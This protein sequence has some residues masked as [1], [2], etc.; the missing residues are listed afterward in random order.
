MQ[1][2]IASQVDL[3]AKRHCLTI[4]PIFGEFLLIQTVF[5]FMSMCGNQ[6]TFLPGSLCLGSRQHKRFFMSSKPA[7]EVLKAWGEVCLAIGVS[8]TL[9]GASL[10]KTP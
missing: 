8:S 5:S 4:I 10:N 6:N 3:N 1:V 9:I 2:L 7:A